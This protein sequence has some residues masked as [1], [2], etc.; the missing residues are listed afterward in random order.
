MYRQGD[1]YI[2]PV[3]KRPDGQLKDDGI[4]AH[5]EATGHK[6]QIASGDRSGASLFEFNN[7][8]FLSVTAEGISIVHEEHNT[9]TIPQGDY[10]VRIQREYS[11]EEIRNVI[12]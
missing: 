3:E 9:V 11:P 12:D 8:L 7:E 1:V 10:S 5:G 4:L 2:I 6:H